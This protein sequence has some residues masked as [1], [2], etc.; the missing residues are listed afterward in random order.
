VLIFDA[1]GG[2]HTDWGDSDRS[3]SGGRERGGEAAMEGP[4]LCVSEGA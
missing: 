2:R 3:P 1:R 4:A